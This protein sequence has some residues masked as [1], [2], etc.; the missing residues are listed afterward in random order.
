MFQRSEN[1]GENQKLCC[2]W[3][4][5]FVA[6]KSH[7]EIGRVNDKKQTSRHIS[8]LESYEQKYIGSIDRKSIRFLLT[9]GK[10]Q[11]QH[12]TRGQ[13]SHIHVR[14]ISVWNTRFNKTGKLC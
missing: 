9:R 8:D 10:I 11:F 6:Y 5:V 14:D 12:V 7:K 3:S 13:H 4:T 1:L 2:S